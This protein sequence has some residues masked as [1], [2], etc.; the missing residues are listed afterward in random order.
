MF[1]KRLMHTMTPFK[2]NYSKDFLGKIIKN[3]IHKSLIILERT[4]NILDI[5]N[6]KL[7]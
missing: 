6:T 5:E 1:I 4:H 7:I 3:R 2:Q